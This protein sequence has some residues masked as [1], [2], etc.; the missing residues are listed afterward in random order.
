MCIQKLLGGPFGGEAFFIEPL[1]L[2][3]ERHVNDDV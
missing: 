1:D 3:F 2:R